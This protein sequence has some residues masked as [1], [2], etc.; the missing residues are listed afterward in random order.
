MT[1]LWF[2]DCSVRVDTEI[3]GPQR[4]WN[5]NQDSIVFTSTRDDSGADG[6]QKAPVE[7]RPCHLAPLTWDK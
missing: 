6:S 4:F 7:N 3:H 2:S 1:E 5:W